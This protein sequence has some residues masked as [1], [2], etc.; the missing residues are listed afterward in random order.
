MLNSNRRKTYDAVT[1]CMRFLESESEDFLSLPY[2][3]RFQ[4]AMQHYQC[5]RGRLQK[6]KMAIDLLQFLAPIVTFFLAYL[7]ARS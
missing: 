5:E 7:I 1:D 2:D 3:R 4:L 6:G